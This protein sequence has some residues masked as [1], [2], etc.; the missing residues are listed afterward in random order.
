ML[1]S[2]PIID[3]LDRKL[4]AEVLDSGVL[5]G[6]EQEKLLEKEWG[7][8]TGSRHSVALSSCAHAIHVALD[9]WGVGPGDEVVVPAFTFIGTVVPVVWCGAR[10]VFVDVDPRTFNVTPELVVAAIGERTKAV[11]PV[12]L[13]G[14]ACDVPGIVAVVDELTKGRA[15][16]IEDACQ[17]QG[18]TWSGRPTGTMGL[19]GCTSL[20]E[21]KNLPGGQGGILHTDD[22]RVA[23]TARERSR[24]GKK[25]GQVLHEVGQSYRI[26]ELSSAIA[27][28]QLAK[29]ERNLARAAD[30]ARVLS[31]E[32]GGLPGVLVPQ[33][34]DEATHTWHKYRIVVEPGQR[35][36]L[37]SSLVEAGVPA[38]RWQESPVPCHPAF[39]CASPSNFP[40]SASAI[41]NSIVVGDERHPLAA[42][43]REEVRRWGKVIKQCVEGGIHV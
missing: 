6:G 4:V 14:L 25:V 18:A 5:Y 32:L 27:R 20:N 33:V 7:D 26:T 13:H 21:T 17:A 36:S 28:A 19:I 41:E 35:E 29:L 40:V 42:Q 9:A 34:P 31:E 24:Y 30:N 3:E 23:R 8:Y 12:H 10:P 11:I 16:V 37:T 2:W 43:D 38:C 1:R 39:G 15:C 22:D